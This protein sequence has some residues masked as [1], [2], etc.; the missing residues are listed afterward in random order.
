MIDH[1]KVVQDIP[2]CLILLINVYILLSLTFNN[3]S[4]L[5][6]FNYNI[7]IVYF[8]SLIVW[9]LLFIKL[10]TSLL[11]L[12]YIIYLRFELLFLSGYWYV[13]IRHWFLFLFIIMGLYFSMKNFKNSLDSIRCCRYDMLNIILAHLEI[14]FLE[15]FSYSYYTC[16][17]EGIPIG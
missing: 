11:F 7:L 6:T 8:N 9:S 15:Y 1:F 2:A 17:I 16:T 3:S 10:V 13:A 12:Y 5:F 4:I 14:D